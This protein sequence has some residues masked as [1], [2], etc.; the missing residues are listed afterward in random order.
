L[1]LDFGGV[2]VTTDWMDMPRFENFN[3]WTMADP[4][5]GCCADINTV[6]SGEVL[7]LGHCPDPPFGVE[8]H[9]IVPMTPGS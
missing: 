6:E 2:M 3:E 1:G 4:R 8:S 5:F 7:Q 9:M